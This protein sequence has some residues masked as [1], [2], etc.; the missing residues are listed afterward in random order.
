MRDIRLCTHPGRQVP[1]RQPVSRFRAFHRGC[2]VDDSGNFEFIENITIK[3]P[4]CL[5]CFSIKPGV[6]R[7]DT[8]RGKASGIAIATVVFARGRLLNFSYYGQKARPVQEKRR[9]MLRGAIGYS[10]RTWRSAWTT[11]TVCPEFKSIARRGRDHTGD[12]GGKSGNLSPVCA[13]CRSRS[14]YPDRS[15][16]RAHPE[17]AWLLMG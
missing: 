5:F 8:I 11:K 16:R 17:G 15:R 9:S 1:E 10:E 2:V 3:R 14:I 6:H 13:V 12:A 7:E 4:H